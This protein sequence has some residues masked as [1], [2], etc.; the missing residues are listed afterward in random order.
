MGITRTAESPATG[1]HTVSLRI[2]DVLVHQCQQRVDP[3][4]GRR[5]WRPART[6]RG[7]ERAVTG[8]L[9]LLTSLPQEPSLT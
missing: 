7:P 3:V 1:N 6:H 8:D 4:T 9:G 2:A 5:T